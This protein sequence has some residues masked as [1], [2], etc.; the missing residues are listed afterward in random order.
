MI[1]PFRKFNHKLRKSLPQPA[2]RV[3]GIDPDT[4]D[5][6]PIESETLPA[7]EGPEMKEIVIA[8]VERSHNDQE[9]VTPEIN[10]PI[11]ILDAPHH[12]TVRPSFSRT[13]V[14][15]GCTS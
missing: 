10:P 4:V 14:Y 9:I 7:P 13:V 11:F 15:C 12:S 8:R 2:P 1:V 5:A 6:S 3:D